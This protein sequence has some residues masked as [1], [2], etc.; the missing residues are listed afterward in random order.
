MTCI[1]LD[2]VR[3]HERHVQRVS[4]EAVNVGRVRFIL[5][6]ITTVLVSGAWITN[7]FAKPL[8]TLFGGSVVLVGIAIAFFTYR[9]ERGRGPSPIFPHV[10][11]H[12]HPIVFMSRGRRLPA[13][14][15]LALLP[16][17]PEQAQTLADLAAADTSGRPVAFLYIA[18]ADTAEK[19][20]QMLEIVDP[21]R[22]DPTA[23]EVFA[24][25]E[26]AAHKARLDSRFIYVPAGV[27]AGAVDWLVGHMAPEETLMLDDGAGLAAA[28]RFTLERRQ[29][30]DTSVLHYRAKASD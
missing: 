16:H 12:Q 19:P 4:H 15:V 25:A 7:L 17:D 2:L 11:Q 3:F 23:Q 21:Y 8:A 20:L 13:A 30:G 24:K 1:A 6:L 18:H 14:G 28:D 26:A 10:Y 5:G 29:A 27:D 22:D 9:R